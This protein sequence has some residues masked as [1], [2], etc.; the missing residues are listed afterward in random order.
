MKKFNKSKVYNKFLLGRQ[1]LL[2]ENGSFHILDLFLHFY[3]FGKSL[4]FTMIFYMY[5][6]SPHFVY[7]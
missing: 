2:F 3:V 7:V 5:D 4:F 1:D 6:L